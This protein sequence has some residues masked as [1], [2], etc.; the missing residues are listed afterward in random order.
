MDHH[1]H[2]YRDLVLFCHRG[3]RDHR[4]IQESEN[5]LSC[6]AS[7]ILDDSSTEKFHP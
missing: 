6:A 2:G 5:E 4:E 3:H 1:Q 7:M